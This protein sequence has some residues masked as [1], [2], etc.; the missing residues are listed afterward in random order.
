MESGFKSSCK[1]IEKA[2]PHHYISN[3]YFLLFQIVVNC[4]GVEAYVCVWC[5]NGEME[6]LKIME[7]L[8]L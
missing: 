5:R 4:C 3:D 8:E 6:S 2:P 7:K 1:G